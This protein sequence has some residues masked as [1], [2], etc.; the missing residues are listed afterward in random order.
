MQ[1]TQ[2]NGPRW[3]QLDIRR[4][5]SCRVCERDV[6]RSAKACPGCG[7]KKPGANAAK[8]FAGDM[9]KAGIGMIFAGILIVILFGGALA[10]IG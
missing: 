6:A 4:T 8:V 7:S 3:Y 2:A 5:V 10:I 1:K 9:A